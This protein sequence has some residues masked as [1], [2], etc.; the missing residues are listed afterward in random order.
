MHTFLLSSITWTHSLLMAT[1]TGR[2]EFPKIFDSR[3]DEGR[4]IWPRKKTLLKESV[5]IL[6]LVSILKVLNKKIIKLQ[7]Q[8]F[9]KVHMYIYVCITLYNEL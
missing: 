1:L 8:Y 4:S 6:L 3:D 2:S 9:I 7:K 5:I